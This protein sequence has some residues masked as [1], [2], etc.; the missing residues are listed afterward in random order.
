MS[1]TNLGGASM[2]DGGCDVFHIL[3]VQKLTSLNQSLRTRRLRT[4]RLMYRN[5]AFFQRKN[6]CCAAVC[7]SPMMLGDRHLYIYI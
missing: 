2:K 1:S 3:G 7:Q 5:V 6:G 4:R